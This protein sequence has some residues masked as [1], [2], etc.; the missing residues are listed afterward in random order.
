M[1]TSLSTFIAVVALAAPV[2]ALA[3]D[4]APSP[5]QNAAQACK[6]QLAKLGAQ[7]FAQTYANFGACV[8]KNAAQAAEN[9]V[10][11]AKTCKAEQADAGFA[12][13]HDGKSFAQ[14]YGTN[15]GNGKGA[16]AN[17]F[18]KCVA[19]HAQQAAQHD[20]QTVVSAA[21][22]CKAMRKS[23]PTGFAAT[24]G[25]AH[26]AFGKCVAAKGK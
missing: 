1:R 26:N 2:A 14:Y 9:A 3:D 12:S 25:K 4:P 23:D 22:T 18:G 8:S 19:Q 6:A 24:Y 21:K 11:A 16:G 10:N 5:A 15:G 13:A 17:A 20:V 7:T